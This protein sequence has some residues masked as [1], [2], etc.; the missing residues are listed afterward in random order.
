VVSTSDNNTGRGL[1]AWATRT[2]THLGVAIVNSNATAMTGPVALS[3][4][5]VGASGSGTI[6]L[7]SYP[8]G[9]AITTPLMNTPGTVSSV[10]VSAGVTAPITV[11]A[12]SV[13]ILSY[14]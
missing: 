3:H 4:W 10:S 5:P 7:W 1:Q 12:D 2:G 8:Q 6:T 13:V 9:G 11:P 14:P